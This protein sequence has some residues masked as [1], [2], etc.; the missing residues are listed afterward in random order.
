MMT[1]AGIHS[2]ATIVNVKL[3]CNVGQGEQEDEWLYGDCGPS[4][5]QIKKKLKRQRQAAAKG[6]HQSEVHVAPSK[7]VRC[8]SMHHHVIGCTIM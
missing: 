5:K 6:R 4:E 1:P 7:I 2:S 3:L 8:D